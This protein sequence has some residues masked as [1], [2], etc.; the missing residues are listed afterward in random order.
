[1]VFVPVGM[2]LPDLLNGRNRNRWFLPGGLVDTPGWTGHLLA[3]RFAPAKKSD[4]L[5]NV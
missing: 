1:M 2:S 5:C 4:Q 3:L